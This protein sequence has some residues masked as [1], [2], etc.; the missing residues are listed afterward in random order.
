MSSWDARDN[1]SLSQQGWDSHVHSCFPSSPVGTILLV[2][3]TPGFPALRG[4]SLQ[5]GPPQ[6]AYQYFVRQ[7]CPADCPAVV[8]A[9]V[10]LNRNYRMHTLQQ[11]VASSIYINSRSVFLRT[12][13]KEGRYVII[14]TTFDP[15]HVGEFLLR[16]FTDVPS[17]CR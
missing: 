2:L 9:Q 17:D 11:K 3:L 15:G 6:G 14:P 16:I 12:D 1:K 13:L 5:S 7:C 10:E 4:Q 8:S